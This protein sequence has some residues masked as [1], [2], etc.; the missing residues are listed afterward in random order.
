MNYNTKIIHCFN[1]KLTEEPIIIFKIL[2]NQYI[3]NILSIL[4]NLCINYVILYSLKEL[5]SSFYY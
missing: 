5:I 2:E 1:Y 3:I 4:T